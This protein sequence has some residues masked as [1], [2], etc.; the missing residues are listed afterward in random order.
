MAFKIMRAGEMI[1]QT[2]RQINE[3][4]TQGSMLYVQTI[5]LAVALAQGIRHDARRGRVEWGAE[6]FAQHS[7][8]THPRGGGSTEDS[9]PLAL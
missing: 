6:S 4:M 1:M 7:H 3:L 8:S 5:M 2:S 9:R